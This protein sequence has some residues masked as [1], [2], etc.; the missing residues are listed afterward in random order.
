MTRRYLHKVFLK[1]R[2]TKKSG[3][4]VVLEEKFG[5]WM[6]SRI[7]IVNICATPVCKCDKYKL[8]QFA[9]A[10]VTLW[11]LQLL[12]ETSCCRMSRRGF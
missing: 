8:G 1:D 2:A 3:T 6:V 10:V 12:E 11:L 7:E 5:G 4:Q 9:V